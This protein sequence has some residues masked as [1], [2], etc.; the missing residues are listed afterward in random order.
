M[1]MHTKKSVSSSLFFV[2]RENLSDNL[3]CLFCA[4]G[5]FNSHY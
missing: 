3:Y 1:S 4:V 5:I 2:S